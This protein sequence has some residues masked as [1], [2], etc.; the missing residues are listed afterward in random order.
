MTLTYPPAESFSYS[1]SGRWRDSMQQK[2]AHAAE[3]RRLWRELVLLLKAKLVAIQSNI[4]TF[5]KE[6]LGDTLLPDGSVVFDWME[7][8]L[9]ETYRTGHMPALLPGLEEQK[10]LGTGEKP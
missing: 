9:A 6:F 10:L 8:Q 2:N 3:I 4:T 1:P 7:P 5:E